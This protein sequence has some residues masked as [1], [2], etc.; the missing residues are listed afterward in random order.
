MIAIALH[1][2]HIDKSI[3][4]L[5]QNMDRKLNHKMLIPELS[6]NFKVKFIFVQVNNICLTF[7]YIKFFCGLY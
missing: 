3:Y 6:D 1:D 7:N 5:L 4:D 2:L